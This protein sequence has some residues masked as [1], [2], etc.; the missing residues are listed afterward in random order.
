[1]VCT[2][3]MGAGSRMRGRDRDGRGNDNIGVGLSPENPAC[4]IP[5]EFSCSHP[6]NPAMQEQVRVR[7]C[8]FCAGFRA[9]ILQNPAH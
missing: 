4:R 5:G 9:R 1:M 8:D 2:M 3:A 7:E 6:Q